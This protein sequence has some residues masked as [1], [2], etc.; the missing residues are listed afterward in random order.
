LNADYTFLN[1]RLARHYGIP[2]V[3]GSTFR[4]VKLTDEN[5]RGLL[6]QGSIL[7]VTSRANRTSP[8]LRGKWVLGSLLGAPPPSPPPNVP[9]LNEDREQV[10]D[11]T[12]RQRM[13][14]HRANPVCASCH[15]GMDPYGF[16]LENFDA[17]GKWRTTEGSLPIDVS[18]VLVDGTRFEGPVGLRELL[19]SR[20]EQFFQN[21]TEKLLTYALGREVDSNDD[22]A[23]EK[24]V[25]EGVAG[26]YRWSSLILGIIKS[27]P[28]Q[29]RRTET[30]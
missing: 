2:E 7:M 12:M 8:V 4:R 6:G 22:P 20:P 29:M 15:V 30:L 21:V 26:G 23:V 18:A 19:L 3:Y 13:E 24:I 14:E 16:A 17:V 10:G 11:L 5:R 27:T 25:Q 1:E 28:F 9:P